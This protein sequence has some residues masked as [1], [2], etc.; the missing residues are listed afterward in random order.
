[1]VA[2][3]AACAAR[4]ATWPG[5]IRGAIFP[6]VSPAS[7]L[8]DLL[9][10]L[11]TLASVLVG[12]LLALRLGVRRTKEER[13]WTARYEA[14]QRIFA[15]VADMRFWV[16]ETIAHVHFLP[17]VGGRPAA[18][19]GDRYYEA[20]RTLFS[21]VYVGGLVISESARDRLEQFMRAVWEEQHRYE[22]D[23]RGE[24][25]DVHQQDLSAH[26]HALQDLIEQ[27]LPAIEGAARA[28]LA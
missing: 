13:R 21:Y 14:Y 17:T 4:R 8:P 22:E 27:H 12:A 28:D 9:R 18:E 10:G 23:A 16:S 25:D 24:E 15:A 7:W 19:L 26:A 3:P 11:V 2:P 20:Q 1:M 6:G 5:R